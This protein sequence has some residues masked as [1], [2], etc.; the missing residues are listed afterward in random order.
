MARI[1]E[2]GFGARGDDPADVL[3][4][5]ELRENENLAS[6]R[7]GPGDDQRRSSGSCVA[8]DSEGEYIY[9]LREGKE[10]DY[11]V[12]ARGKIR[13]REDALG[14]FRGGHYGRKTGNYL[15]GRQAQILSRKMHSGGSWL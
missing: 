15:P 9:V 3:G 13:P 8:E 1:I 4:R 14:D 2:H 5:G 11:D 10:N 7:R 12:V 6:S